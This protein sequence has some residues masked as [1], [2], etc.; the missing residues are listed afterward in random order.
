MGPEPDYEEPSL[1]IEEDTSLFPP[2]QPEENEISL[3]SEDFA[4]PSL[5]Q[6]ELEEKK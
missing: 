1:Q 6:K 2:L 3:T 5:E 4:Q